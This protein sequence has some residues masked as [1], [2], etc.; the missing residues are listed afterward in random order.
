MKYYIYISDAKVDM[1]LAQIPH[2]IKKKVATEFKVDLKL[3]TASR[4]SEIEVENNRYTRL[5]A[6]SSFITEY[7]NVGTVDKPSDYIADTIDMRW[8]PF[9]SKDPTNAPL[10]YFGGVTGNTVLGLGGSMSHVIGAP[11]ESDPPSTPS[12]FRRFSIGPVLVHYL[13]REL[14]L[15]PGYELDEFEESLW[16]DFV[17]WTT[18]QMRGPRQRL[19]FMAKRLQEGS[20]AG[21]YVEAEGGWRVIFGTPLYVAIA[22]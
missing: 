9:G 22:D 21:K 15:H 12:H 7:G 18:L 10:V 14:N 8:G 1:L 5:A 11:G 17:F 2:D 13:K 20:P 19:E 3:L 16:A 4:K 6:V